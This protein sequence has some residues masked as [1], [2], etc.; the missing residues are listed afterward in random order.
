[1]QVAILNFDQFPDQA[2]ELLQA[3]K[4]QCCPIPVLVVSAAMIASLDHEAIP[5]GAADYLVLEGLT[6]YQLA[7]AIRYAIERKRTEL[8]LARLA[9][10]D[11]LT[12]IPNRVLFRD[13]LENAIRIAARDRMRFA[14]MFIDL[15]DF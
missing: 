7:R 6:A 2:R 3:V 4:H 11:P 9:H 15:N 10:H 14:L 8:T 1:Y 5:L 13:R 12:D